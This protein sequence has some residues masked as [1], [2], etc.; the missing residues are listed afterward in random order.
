MNIV[1]FFRILW[2]RRMIVIVATVACFAAGLLAI[3]ILPRTYAATSRVMLDVNKPDP[4]AADEISANFA[5]T[6]IPTEAQVIMD[7]RVAARAAENLGWTNDPNQQAAYRDYRDANADR[8]DV[9]DFD[10]WI[11]QQI[12]KNVVAQQFQQTNFIDITYE[13]PSANDAATMANA[14]RQAYVD[15]ATAGKRRDAVQAAELLGRQMDEVRTQREGAEQKLVA[16]Q[17]AN[18]IVLLDN[19]SDAAS[20]R[21]QA[22]ANA[23]PNTGGTTIVGGSVANPNAAGIAAIDAQIANQASQLGPNHPAIQE[24][25]RQRAALASAPVGSAPRTVNSGPSVASAV[26]AEGA[27]V[28]A[29]KDK[30]EE[31]K[32]MAADVQVLRDQYQTMA[33]RAAVLR[34]QSTASD[35]TVVPMAAASPPTWPE[36]PKLPLVLIGSFGL[37][38]VIGVLV[39]LILEFLR[40]RVRGVDDLVSAADVP[41]I[42]VINAPPKDSLSIT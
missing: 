38:L 7:Y 28:L 21:L 3:A 13:A 15:E 33:A 20:A 10:H 11:A 34:Q 22:L 40:R 14:V 12:T 36:S 1:Q 16:F 5:R 17:R 41:V 31:A 29:Q 27:R 24:L 2:A 26:Q 37:G 19:N 9:L 4:L 25:R 39:A 18:G 42:G 35:F 32:R 23:A 30:V 8:A 6:Y